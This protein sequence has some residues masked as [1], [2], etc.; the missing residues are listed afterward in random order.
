MVN[1]VTATAGSFLW[2]FWPSVAAAEANLIATATASLGSSASGAYVEPS[3]TAP[4]G[5]VLVCEVFGVS[6]L[7]WSSTQTGLFIGAPGAPGQHGQL[8]VIVYNYPSNTA[9]PSNGTGSNSTAPTSSSTS[10]YTATTATP[11]STPVS[12]PQQT[13]ET[14]GAFWLYMRYSSGYWSRLQRP[15]DGSVALITNQTQNAQQFILQNSVLVTANSN[16]S[17]SVQT[18]DGTGPGFYL[19][20]WSSV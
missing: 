10:T 13:P 4:D 17:L 11:L 18:S 2:E 16:F 6:Q 19:E 20:F 15:G 1:S 12:L 14:I 3:C 5:Y 8:V 9:A 7:Q